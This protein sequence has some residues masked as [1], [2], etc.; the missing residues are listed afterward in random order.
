MS[1]IY[2]NSTWKSGEKITIDGVEYTVGTDAF[3]SY[4][5]AY[6]YAIAN[7]KNSTIVLQT[8]SGQ[9]ANEH[10]NYRYL[11]VTAED[12]TTLWYA[13]NKLDMTYDVVVKAGASFKTNRPKNSASYVH[14]KDGGSLTL[15]E[16]DS[17]ERAVLDFGTNASYHNID[18][19]VLW[20]GSFTAYNADVTVGDLSFNGPGNFTGCAIKVEGALASGSQMG[21]LTLNDT[22]I[23]VI[24]NHQR[25]YTGANV[26]FRGFNQLKNITMTNGSSIKIDDGADGIV[27]DK[28][29]MDTVKMDNSSITVEKGT[30]V[31]VVNTVTMTGTATLDVGALDIAAKKKIV[32]DNTASIVADALTGTG[33]IE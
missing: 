10:K 16:A 28:V 9:I 21:K 12:G 31:N 23:V 32:I 2:V 17:T 14:V 1:T 19:A 25:L 29:T 27:A 15:G 22:D 8:S 5:A 20:Q 11:N 7:A 24:G 6:S 3:T 33:T 26:Y 13:G 4:N 18:F 30:A